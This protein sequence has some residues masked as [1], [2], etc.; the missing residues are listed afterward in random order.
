MLVKVTLP[1]ASGWVIAQ[2]S[3]HGPPKS[4]STSSLAVV[5]CVMCGL[6]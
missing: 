3:P 4:C 6:G 5:I 2:V 1:N